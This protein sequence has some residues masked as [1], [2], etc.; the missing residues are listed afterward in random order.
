MALQD[1]YRVLKS[2]LSPGLN[3]AARDGGQ[4][5]IVHPSDMNGAAKTTC[6]P[7]GWGGEKAQG[8]LRKLALGQLSPP[9]RVLYT[10]GA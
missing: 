9:G 3:E 5:W 8:H 6:A 1:Y 7:G 2:V 10:P 4:D